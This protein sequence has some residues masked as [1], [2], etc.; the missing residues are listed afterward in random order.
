ML[1]RLSHSAWA[2]ASAQPTLQAVIFVTPVCRTKSYRLLDADG[3]AFESA[4]KGCSAAI[5]AWIK[6]GLT[7]A[8]HRVFFADEASAVAAGF[9]PCGVCM[10]AAYQRWRATK[11]KNNPAARPNTKQSTYKPNKKS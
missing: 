10:R 8:R 3:R 2:S 5:A 11:Q 6:R 1:T 4:T 9:R 7:D